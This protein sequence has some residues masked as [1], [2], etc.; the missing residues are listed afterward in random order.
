MARSIREMIL[1]SEMYVEGYTV[2]MDEETRDA[3]FDSHLA[4]LINT[5]IQR[6][7]E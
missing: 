5:E 4:N 1:E 3:I 2:D 7:G 6:E